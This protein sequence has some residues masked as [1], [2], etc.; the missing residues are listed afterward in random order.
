MRSRSSSNQVPPNLLGRNDA[1]PATERRADGFQRPGRQTDHES[2]G[3]AQ[4]HGGGRMTAWQPAQC[5]WQPRLPNR[6]TNVS[7]RTL[8]AACP[9]SASRCRLTIVRGPRSKL[10][11]IISREPS[12][13]TPTRCAFRS[14]HEHLKDLANLGNDLPNDKEM[15][16]I[17]LKDKKASN[18]SIANLL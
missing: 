5:P 11:T 8:T 6:M 9:E 12:S 14:S 16:N 10:P 2:P 1:E 18:P 7:R 13:W 17:G 4:D 3:K 15:V